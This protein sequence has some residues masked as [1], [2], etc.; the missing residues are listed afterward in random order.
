MISDVV[1]REVHITHAVFL[2]QNGKQHTTQIYHLN[3][4]Q[5]YS[6][7]ALTICTL[8]CNR[9]VERFLSCK[10][11]LYIYKQ[12]YSFPSPQPL[13]TTILPFVSKS[14][15][16]LDTS[17][18]WNH[19]YLSSNWPTSPSIMSQGSSMLQHMIK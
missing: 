3:H 13:A 1:Q 7:I 6:T 17:P 12:L 11:N 2:F 16:A 18:K 10:T 9:S 19:Q 4:S 5:V 8:L 14:L 15:T